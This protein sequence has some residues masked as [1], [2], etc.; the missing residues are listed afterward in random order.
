MIGAVTSAATS[1][2]GAELYNFKQNEER[3]HQANQPAPSQ[4]SSPGGQPSSVGQAGSVPTQNP[5][6]SG[7]WNNIAPPVK[8]P[9]GQILAVNPNTGRYEVVQS[10]ADY[11]RYG[12]NANESNVTMVPGAASLAGSAPGGAPVGQPGGAPGGQPGGAPGGAGSAESAFASAAAGQAAQQAENNAIAA[13]QQRALQ[14]YYEGQVRGEDERLAFDKAIQAYTETYNAEKL[15]FEQQREQQRI[16]EA[17][18]QFG[19]TEAG[20]TGTY[21]G[22]PTEARLAREQTGA[23]GL[24]NQAATLRGPANAFQALRTFGNTPQGLVDVVN[25]VAGRYNLPTAAGLTGQGSAPA[26]LQSLIAGL[27]PANIAADQA[28]AASATRGLPAPNQFN[29]ANWSRL[30]PSQQ[31][32]V[33]GAYE[34][35][36]GPGGASISP[37]DLEAMIRQSA[38]QFRAP[39]SAQ[40]QF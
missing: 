24:L 32:V 8:D 34:A 35:G 36:L 27:Q 1:K 33:A 26:T 10:P 18:Q 39:S 25:A 16:L 21:Q 30:L 23:L 7:A 13:A 15:K 2:T 31:Q 19:L 17:A 14:V 6:G 20:V 37:S 22:A 40:F 11:G 5:G 38:P 28:A 9:N 3:A 12:I 29:L 4:P